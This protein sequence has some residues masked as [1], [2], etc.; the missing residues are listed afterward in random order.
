MK[1][2]HTSTGRLPSQTFHA[3]VVNFMTSTIWG[4]VIL[5]DPSNGSPYNARSI[6]LFF[7]F[8]K[9]KKKEGITVKKNRAEK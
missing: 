7:F 3:N 4:P 9:K 6:W 5:Y 8:F 2:G 1:K